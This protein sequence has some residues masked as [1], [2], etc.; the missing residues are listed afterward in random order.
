MDLV[1][2]LTILGV[3]GIV[4]GIICGIFML[5][6]NRT[7]ARGDEKNRQ[8]EATRAERE[9]EIKAQNEAME[10]QNAALML[11]LQAILRDR[12]LQGYR[13]YAQK[14]WADYEDRG[15]MEN[16][17]TQ[18]HALGANGVMD[19]YRVKFL[20]LPEYDPQTAVLNYHED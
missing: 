5:K 9:K 13:H 17:Y 20:Q 2:I 12:L 8:A 16:M 3:P 19:G 15:N 1:Q 4:S 7:I 10:R 18:Y 6:I 14:G 11:G